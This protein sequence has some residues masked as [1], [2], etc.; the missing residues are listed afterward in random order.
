MPALHRTE[1]KNRRQSATETLQEFSTDLSRLGRLAFPTA[2]EDLL[3]SIIIDA[4]ADGV[5][6][7]DLQ[8]TLKLTRSSTL[9]ETLAK[10]MEFEAVKKSMSRGP[11]RIRQTAVEDEG[12]SGGIL[13]DLKKLLEQIQ[14][15]KDSPRT[16]R[17]HQL[18]CYNCQQ[19]GHF[20]RQ[21]RLPPR[22]ENQDNNQGNDE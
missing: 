8:Q 9:G 1:I 20:K 11:M 17:K 14:S 18:K 2:P 21:C 4:F 12:K 10:A 15:N 3:E 13:Q 16:T 5:R 7:P 19:P 22:Q 6:D